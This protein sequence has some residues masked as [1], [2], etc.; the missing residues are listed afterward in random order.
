MFRISTRDLLWLTLVIGLSV[1]LYIERSQAELW[2]A[3]A[4]YVRRIVRD[5]GWESDWTGPTAKFEHVDAQP[6]EN[7]PSQAPNGDSPNGKEPG[8]GP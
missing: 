1:A 5:L 7:A 3:R 8:A 4:D 6:A 2:H